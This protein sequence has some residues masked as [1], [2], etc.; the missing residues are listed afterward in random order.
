VV[1]SLQFDGFDDRIYQVLRGRPLLQEKLAILDLLC[2]QDI[3]TS[4]TMVAARNVSEDAFGPILEKLLTVPNIISWMI[5]PM[6]Y[7]GRGKGFPVPPRRLTIPEIL[8]LLD[9]TGKAQVSDFTPLPCC[10]PV[11]FSLAFYLMLSDGE[12]ISIG[13]IVDTS[14][15]LDAIQNKAIF[16]LDEKEHEQ[17]KTMVY[18]LWS[19][20][21]ATN[22]ESQKVLQTVR[23]LLREISKNS[24]ACFNPREVFS[25][26]E[27]KVKSIFV[28]AF[29]DVDTFD[30]ARVRRCC[31]GYP[32]KDGTVIPACVRNVLRKNCK[33]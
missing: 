17:I 4:L 1:L 10:H 18:E 2:S 6:V 23:G 15:W 9:K 31:N 24:C 8:K 3:T 29:Q 27:R 30:L 28:H 16:G 13:K 26:S 32:Q 25:I 21:A 5:Q 20:P 7:D 11:C 14:R 12:H 33:T 19:G 22:P